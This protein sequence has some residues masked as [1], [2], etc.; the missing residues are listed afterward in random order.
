MLKLVPPLSFCSVLNKKE[1]DL[2]CIVG[3]KKMPTLF[4]RFQNYSHC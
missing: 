3:Q 2:E 4:E 1:R